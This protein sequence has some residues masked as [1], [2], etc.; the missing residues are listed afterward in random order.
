MQGDNSVVEDMVP[1]RV[2]RI[3]GLPAMGV[4]WGRVGQR[5]NLS[6]NLALGALLWI[7]NSPSCSAVGCIVNVAKLL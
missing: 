4:H 2:V 1:R 7:R 5:Q 6:C 3:V